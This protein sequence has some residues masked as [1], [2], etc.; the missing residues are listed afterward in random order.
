ML[1]GL[2]RSEFSPFLVVLGKFKLDVL[3]VK[4]VVYIFQHLI[5]F[6]TLLLVMA[7]TRASCT[8][9]RSEL[10]FDI[11]VGLSSIW[12][13]LPCRPVILFRHNW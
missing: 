12:T 13:L 2:A 4:L 1:T 5:A 10:N 9:T 3:L 8:S 6:T 7:V 11:D